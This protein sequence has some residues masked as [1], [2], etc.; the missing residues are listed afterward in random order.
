M[1]KITASVICDSIGEHSPRLT[2]FLTH[3]PKFVHAEH[4][5]HRAF[6]LCV[7]SSRAIPSKRY[8]EIVR[9]D[10]ERAE[11]AFW[12]TEQKGMSPGEEIPSDMRFENLNGWWKNYWHTGGATVRETWA[13]AACV[14][15]DIAE[16]LIG[17]GVH[18]SI[19]NRL[20]D[21]FV[22]V[23]VL[24]T[25]CEVGLLN[26]FGLRLDKSADPTIRALAE[27]MWAAWNESNPQKLE[28]GE[29]HLPFVDDDENGLFAKTIEL[30]YHKSGNA[31]PTLMVSAA[32]CARLSYMSNETGKRSTIEE[33][34]ALYD[35]LI[36]AKPIHAS[37]AE[38]QA[39]PDTREPFD[40]GRPMLNPPLGPWSHSELHGNLPGWVQYRKTLP[41]EAIAS[42]PEGYIYN[43]AVR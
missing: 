35:R 37:P 13:E 2:T 42:L 16:S 1:S 21:P 18:K 39:T 4:C 30:E 17:V 9:S 36:T 28:P 27:A 33:D 23:N 14:V 34:L 20:L 7:S 26:W 15:A 3:Y 11:P 38:H 10:E 6:S 8:L 12:G 22:P 25:S 31:P 19:A 43:G 40:S 24:V 32:R 5:R 29:W 41:N